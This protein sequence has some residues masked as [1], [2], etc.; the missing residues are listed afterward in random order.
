ML[1]EL[2]LNTDEVDEGIDL[3]LDEMDKNPDF[4]KGFSETYIPS[5][6]VAVTKPKED[7]EKDTE[8]TD[9]KNKWLL[10]VGIAAGA[11]LLLK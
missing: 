1:K 3:G 2:N 8:P 7:T 9:E 4:D 6:T 5:G 10:P 11:Y